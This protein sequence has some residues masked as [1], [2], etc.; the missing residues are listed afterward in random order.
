MRSSAGMGTPGPQRFL[1]FQIP[2]DPTR[3][4]LLNGMP[5]RFPDLLEGD[6]ASRRVCQG[7]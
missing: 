7:S 4:V 5:V 6:G 1:E 2:L 3:R